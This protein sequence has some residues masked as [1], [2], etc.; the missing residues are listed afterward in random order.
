MIE[1]SI[2]L[3]PPELLYNLKKQLNY[4]DTV[5]V[6]TSDVTSTACVHENSLT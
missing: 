2:K 5:A 4:V 1:S 3:P 6:V